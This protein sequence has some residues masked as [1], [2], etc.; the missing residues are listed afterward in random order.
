MDADTIALVQSV[1]ERGTYFFCELVWSSLPSVV[2][3]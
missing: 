1:A 3:L 2:A